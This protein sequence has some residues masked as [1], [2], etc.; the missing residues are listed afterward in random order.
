V[1]DNDLQLGKPVEDAADDHAQTLE[2]D[3]LMPS[4]A[5]APRIRLANVSP[6]PS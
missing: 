3:F 5:W 1:A 2:R 6:S 4:I